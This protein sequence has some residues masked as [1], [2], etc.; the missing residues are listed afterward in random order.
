MDWNEFDVWSPHSA[1]GFAR[2]Q[3]LA[4][5]QPE[6]EAMDYARRL[7]AE[8]L[9]SGPAT[10]L[11]LL[12]TVHEAVPGGPPVGHLWLRV[13]PLS[14]EVEAFVFDVELRAQARGRGLGRATMLA[15]ED[16]A[17]DLGATVVRLNVFGHNRVARHLYE[18]LGFTV[19][20]ATMTKSL[21]GPSRDGSVTRSVPAVGLRPMT[22]E[23]F[24]VF[25][26]RVEE[27]LARNLARSGTLPPQ[28]ARR[29]ARTDLEQLLP[30]GRATPGHVLRTA[31]AAAGDGDGD[32]DGDSDG[33]GDGDGDGDEVPVGVV[34]LQLRER[35]AGRYAVAVDLEV[36]EQLRGRGYGR[37][38]ARE[39]QRLC[40]ED[41]AGSIELSVFG[42]ND[43]ARSLYE[44]EGFELT[45]ATMVKAL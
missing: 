38:V 39:A 24:G 23:Q 28:E 9:P 33:D 20:T 2:Q 29:R 5:L 1:R 41:G 45:A 42:F 36:R 15:A 3:V 19:A 21:T 43:V 4:G 7:L 6:Q 35:S 13:R 44:S 30:Q 32:G 8:L 31:F 22:E 37:A 16:A 10:P 17:R 18:S 12:W 40:R 25:R 14:S 11:H 27:D 34:W 26:P